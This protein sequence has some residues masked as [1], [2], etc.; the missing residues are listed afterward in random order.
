MNYHSYLPRYF[1]ETQQLRDEIRQ[2]PQVQFVLK[3]YSA[4][5]SNNYIK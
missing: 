3:V 1:R 5:N 2:S 4:L